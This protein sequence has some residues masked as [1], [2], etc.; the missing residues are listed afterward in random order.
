MK[1]TLV[2]SILVWIVSL[3]SAQASL[4]SYSSGARLYEVF[5]HFF[6]NEDDAGRFKSDLS[7]LNRTEKRPYFMEN[8][9]ETTWG[10]AGDIFRVDVTYRD[11]RLDQRL[12]FMDDSGYHDLLGY[13]DV[14]KPPLPLPGGNLR[15]RLVFYVDR[16]HRL[17]GR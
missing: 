10:Q 11:A 15:S 3:S 4:S 8:G 17:H 16:Y 1:K 6:Y 9:S 12:G 13:A 5:N 14:K 2:I 7:L